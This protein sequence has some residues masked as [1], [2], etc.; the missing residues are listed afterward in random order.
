MAQQPA[1]WQM[2]KEAIAHLGGTATYGAIRDFIKDKYG[3]ANESTMTC[4]IIS[5]SVNHPTRVHYT[6]NQKPRLCDSQYDFLFHMG[7]GKVELYDPD[8]HGR[9][10]IR[11]DE[12]GKLVVAQPDLISEESP[13][14][15]FDEADGFLFPLESHLRD[16][17]AANLD[18]IKLHN[19]ALRLYED[20]SGHDGVEYPTDVGRI[21]ILAQASNGDLVVF[22]L[23]LSKGP[24]RAVGQALRY[25]GWVSKHLAVGKK[26]SGV[27]VALEIDEKLKYA[28]SL[29][30]NITLFEYK[31]R[32]DLNQVS[33]G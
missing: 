25:M 10:Q 24:D 33:L 28:V 18:S 3:A 14:E 31:L 8:V 2:V 29:V 20:S 11:R 9:W 32:F 15:V 21:D 5:C 1:V 7:R 17:I 22:E 30:P 13:T 16:F 23:K 12:Y 6:P 19:V 4:Q 26:V 27:I